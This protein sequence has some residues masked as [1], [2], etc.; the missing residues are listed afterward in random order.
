[1]V[2]KRERPETDDFV[3]KKYL[4]VNEKYY[5]ILRNYSQTP[6]QKFLNIYLHI[7]AFQNIPSILY[8][9]PAKTCIFL[10][11]KGFFYGSPYS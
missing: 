2:L 5:N 3:I 9:F 7:L 4:V 1:M 11:D 6:L 10:A 8:F